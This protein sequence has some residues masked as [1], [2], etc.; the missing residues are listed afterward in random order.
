MH[1]TFR[2]KFGP[3]WNLVIHNK[4]LYM[5]LCGNRF[6]IF[7]VHSDPSKAKEHFVGFGR[8]SKSLNVTKEEVPI[9]VDQK[10][11]ARCFKCIR[12]NMQEIYD[13]RVLQVLIDGAQGGDTRFNIFS[14]RQCNLWKTN[15]L[16]AITD[17]LRWWSLNRNE[18]V[19]LAR[20]KIIACILAFRELAT[21]WIF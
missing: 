13:S 11:A 8:H 17:K 6:P 10:F 15:R 7:W 14:R 4:R 19:L 3:V 5:K 2:A 9:V 1:I 20:E 18:F 21:L 16:W 12:A